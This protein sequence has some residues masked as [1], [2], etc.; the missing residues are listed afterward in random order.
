MLKLDSITLLP[1]DPKAL[2]EYLKKLPPEVLKRF[3]AKWQRKD[4]ADEES[5][6]VKNLVQT[7][8]RLARNS[9]KH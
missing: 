2:E 4:K 8:S 6:R 3:A 9:N 7:I 5:E 1:D